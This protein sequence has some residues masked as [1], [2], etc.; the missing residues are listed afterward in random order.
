MRPN[1]S[2]EK[3][4]AILKPGSVYRRE[5]FLALSSN[6]DRNL[7]ILLRSGFLKRERQGLYSCPQHT[8]FG[9]AL[10]NEQEMVASFLR[11]NRFV[12]YSQNSFNS[13][14]FGTT[15]L[16]NKRIVFNRKRVGEYVL[17]GRSY[18]FYRWREAPKEVTKEFLL[19]E[20]LNKLTELAED[21][22]AILEKM[23]SKLSLFDRRKLLFSASH[24]GKNSTQQILK[25][26]LGA[27][28]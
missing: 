28:E 17:A 8:E 4:K 24:Y 26:W 10:P 20:F 5:D 16:Y 22:N 3:I 21:S 13:L 12:V 15:Q 14:G 18:T 11:D 19:V 2:L 7:A 9:D 6:V 27:N 1:Q 23:H 25:N